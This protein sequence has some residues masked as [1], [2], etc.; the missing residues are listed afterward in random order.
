MLGQ[1]FY[2]AEHGPL[3]AGIETESAQQLLCEPRDRTSLL[4][5]PDFKKLIRT[6]SM[7]Q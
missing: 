4:W 2:W 7:H 3:A 1:I 5:Q 6:Y